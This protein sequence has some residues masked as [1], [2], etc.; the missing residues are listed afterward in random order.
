MYFYSLYMVPENSVTI[1]ALFSLTQ[2]RKA[3]E[4]WSLRTKGALIY[5]NFKKVWSYSEVTF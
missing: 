4:N 1:V 5:C 2:Q 3:G